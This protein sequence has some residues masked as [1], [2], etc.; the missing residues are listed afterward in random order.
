MEWNGMEEEEKKIKQYL[1]HGP[2]C[3]IFNGFCCRQEPCLSSHSLS[4]VFPSLAQILRG[5]TSSGHFVGH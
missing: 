2:S 5:S 1:L 4:Y 3:S